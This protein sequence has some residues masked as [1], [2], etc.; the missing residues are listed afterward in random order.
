MR[1]Q[2]LQWPVTHRNLSIKKSG[3]D[4]GLL[5]Q[6]G[7]GVDQVAPGPADNP[8][9]VSVSS[10]SSVTWPSGEA[11]SSG[12]CSLASTRPSG[13]PFPLLQ[14]WKD[15]SVPLI[16]IGVLGLRV[17]MNCRTGWCCL[18]LSKWIW[19]EINHIRAPGRGCPGHRNSIWNVH[20]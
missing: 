19:W 8:A 6:G 5:Q 4:W 16:V 7:G 9:W 2:T 12:W 17:E 18:L 14:T 20:S 1:T 3:M 10:C 11:C 15:R 13:P